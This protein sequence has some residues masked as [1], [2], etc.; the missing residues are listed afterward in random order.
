MTT[1]TLQ[2]SLSQV[3][4]AL[5]TSKVFVVPSVSALAKHL[6][7]S[8]D[9]KEKKVTESLTAFFSTT[10]STSVA[11]VPSDE[12][13]SNQKDIK[14]DGTDSSDSS[15]PVVKAKPS[16]L[17][18]ATESSEEKPVKGKAPIKADDSSE[19]PVKPAKGKAVKADDSL[20]EP[21]KPVKGKAVKADDSSEEPVKPVKGKA[22][23]AD[24][25]SEE[26][27]KPVK[28]KAVKA[29][30]PAPADDSSEEPVKPVKGKTV[31][32]P[33]PADDSSEEPVKPAKGKGKADDSEEP[34]KGNGKKVK[35]GV[36][37][38]SSDDEQPK[39]NE[40]SEES[41][42]GKKKANK[43]KKQVDESD[44]DEPPV[45][46]AVEK[47][48]TKNATDLQVV[49]KCTGGKDWD[50]PPSHYTFAQ[51][52]NFIVYDNVVVGGWGKAG[53]R[54]LNKKD[55]ESCENKGWKVEITEIDKIQ[56]KMDKLVL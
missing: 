11:G 18:T 21:V 24:D 48:S 5:E 41:S 30:V 45:P 52:T 47:V 6:S 28:G 35:P 46:V 16:K 26:P 7:S 15:E 44:Q 4:T 40:L 31:K 17:A 50:T 49:N 56:K 10:A 13:F 55:V 33:V 39:K 14:G 38:D 53:I 34:V 25:S 54:K 3:V 27:V 51:K 12:D 9:V 37:A 20:E 8:L 42:D 43:Q 1:V 29:P 23:K 22:V 36:V 2:V 32:A 19:E